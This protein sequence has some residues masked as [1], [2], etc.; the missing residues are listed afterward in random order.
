VVEGPMQSPFQGAFSASFL[1]PDTYRILTIAS[2]GFFKL[3]LFLPAEYPMC[4]PKVTVFQTFLKFLHFNST[5][6]RSAF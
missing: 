2:G 5:S 4:A 6:F 1:S 3:E